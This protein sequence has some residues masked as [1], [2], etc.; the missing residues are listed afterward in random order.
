[1]CEAPLSVSFAAGEPQATD[2]V[3]WLPP[4]ACGHLRDEFCSVANLFCSID[5]VR[6]WAATTE[7]AGRPMTVTAAADWGAHVWRDAARAVADS[8]S[9]ASTEDS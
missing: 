7:A 9:A 2:A 3:L 8:L 1:M 6:G 4:A 5:H